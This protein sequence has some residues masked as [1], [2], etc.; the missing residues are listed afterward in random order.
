LLERCRRGRASDPGEY[1]YVL[2]SLAIGAPGDLEP[3]YKEPT[4]RTF[5]R[6]ARQMVKTLG[7]TVKSLYSAS[8]GVGTRPGPGVVGA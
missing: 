2:L 4:V 3:D 6:Y 5:T 7:V 1:V 8:H